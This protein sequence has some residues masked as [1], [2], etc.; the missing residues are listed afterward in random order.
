VAGVLAVSAL[1]AGALGW[2]LAQRRR[3]VAVDVVGES[4]VP[5]LAPGT[6]VLVRRRSLAGIRVGD[7]VVVEQPAGR[8]HRWAPTAGR[9]ADRRWMIKRV[10]ALPGDPVP[11]EV[12]DAVGAAAGARVPAGCLVLLGDNPSASSDSRE[13]GFVPAD[14]LLGVAPLPVIKASFTSS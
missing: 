6:R 3:L 7:V 5:A 8:D 4:M 2:L 11:A 12:A 1:L 14:R 13:F 10:A 9:I